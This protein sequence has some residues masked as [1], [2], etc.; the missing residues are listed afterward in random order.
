MAVHVP[1]WRRILSRGQCILRLVPEVYVTATRYYLSRC[2]R[3]RRVALAVA[4]D[5]GNEKAARYRDARN[6]GA[7]KF[8]RFHGERFPRRNVQ[9]DP[10]DAFWSLHVLRARLC[11]NFSSSLEFS[12]HRYE[13]ERDE[14]R[15][16][17]NV[18]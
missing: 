7:G 3:H 14:C 15:E 8:V 10:P 4:A 9:R 2:R 18:Y 5:A 16:D 1:A 13:G 17:I 11:S 12:R 6:R